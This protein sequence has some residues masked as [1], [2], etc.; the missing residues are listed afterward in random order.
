MDLLERFA[1][2]A[3]IALNNAQ[4]HTQLKQE[5]IELE[6]KEETIRA[7]FDAT[8]DAIFVHD[9]ESAELINCNRK[10]EELLGFTL[11]EVQQMGIA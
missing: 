7:I 3:S 2:M 5:L 9:A 10:T 8:N 11:E 6:R 1:S 4:L